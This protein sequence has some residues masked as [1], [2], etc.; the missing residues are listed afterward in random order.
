MCAGHESGNAGREDAKALVRVM[1]RQFYPLV[2]DVV[3][4]AVRSSLPPVVA[5]VPHVVGECDEDRRLR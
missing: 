1:L 4:Y 5:S 2:A 3:E